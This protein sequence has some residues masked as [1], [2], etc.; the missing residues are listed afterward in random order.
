MMSSQFYTMPQHPDDFPE[1][2]VMLPPVRRVPQKKISRGEY[3]S[4][5]V[6]TSDKNELGRVSDKKAYSGSRKSKGRVERKND[7]TSCL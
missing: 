3:R 5:N 4:G 6:C 2:G 7:T 1:P